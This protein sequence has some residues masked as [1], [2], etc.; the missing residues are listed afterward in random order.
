MKEF[1]PEMQEQ[2]TFEVK[3]KLLETLFV[4]GLKIESPFETDAIYH[5]KA[6][7]SQNPLTNRLKRDMILSYSKGAWAKRSREYENA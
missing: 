3:Q 7:K 5:F 1:A 4:P 6:K 2:K